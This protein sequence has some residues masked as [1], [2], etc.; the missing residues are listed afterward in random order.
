MYTLDAN[1]DK[2]KQLKFKTVVPIATD[3]QLRS[4]QRCRLQ[5]TIYT[6]TTH[7]RSNRYNTVLYTVSKYPIYSVLV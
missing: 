6:R 7:P 2:K 1:D 5:S 3:S 4:G